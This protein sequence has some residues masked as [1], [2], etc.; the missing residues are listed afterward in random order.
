MITC[1]KVCLPQSRF[2]RQTEARQKPKKGELE[3]LDKISFIG[4]ALIW[5]LHVSPP[6]RRTRVAILNKGG[7]RGMD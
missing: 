2:E 5:N 4:S 1:R 6:A 3:N 7:K